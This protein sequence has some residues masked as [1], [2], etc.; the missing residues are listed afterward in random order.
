MKAWRRLIHF[1]RSNEAMI[2]DEMNL[3]GVRH[4]LTFVYEIQIAFGGSDTF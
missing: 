2:S 4:W 1:T 3:A